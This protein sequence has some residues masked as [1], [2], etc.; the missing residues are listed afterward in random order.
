MKQYMNEEMMKKFRKAFPT[1]IS[2]K[3]GKKR[4]NS[5]E[6]SFGIA[7]NPFRAY[8]GWNGKPGEIYRQWAKP[9][10]TRIT[11]L[12]QNTDI[13][14]RKA[15]LEWHKGL[16]DSLQAHWQKHEGKQLPLAHGYKLVDLYIKWL[17][18]HQFANKP[19]LEGIL[20]NANCA[21]D[22]QILERLNQCYSMALPV[23]KP[24]MGHIHNQ[25]TY[26]LCQTL[27]GEFSENC[28]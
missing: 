25:N 24:S 14:S 12:D 23:F 19:F 28:G 10:T 8:R 13:S 15:F 17:S 26:D 3:I 2:S 11:Q 22:S 1:I 21:L 27:I 4:I 7:G 16:Y 9:T 5:D 18:S 6:A 20:R